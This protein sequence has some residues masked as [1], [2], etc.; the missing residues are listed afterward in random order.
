MILQIEPWIDTEELEQLKRIIETTYVTEGPLTSEFENLTKE[1][2]QSKNAITVSNGTVGLFCAL[3]A[4]GIGENDE[5]IVPNVT[6][7]ASANSV[8]M[9][10]AKPIFCD[11][12]T[13][14]PA[15]V[16]ITKITCLMS[17][18]RPL[19]SVKEP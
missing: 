4:L 8:L 11:S 16:V 18:V 12:I 19:V 5:V 14:A 1:L 10:G 6:F 9:A 17:A 15:L 2:T 7:I 13:L 3:K